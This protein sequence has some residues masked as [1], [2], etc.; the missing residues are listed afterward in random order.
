[1]QIQSDL[2]AVLARAGFELK[3]W[4]IN[5]PVLLSTIPDGDRAST[6][7]DFNG[8]E[9]P[10]VKVLGLQWDPSTDDFGYNVHIL[11]TVVTKRSVLS[12]IAQIFDPLGFL[13]P[14][15]FLAKHIMQLIWKANLS[16][17]DPLPASLAANWES[18]VADLPCLLNIR[19][20]RNQF[21]KT[22]AHVQLCGCCDASERGYSAVVYM[23][24]RQ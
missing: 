1:M 20:P 4:S 21:A 2:K 11:T 9:G 3:K 16:W 19:V 8:N 18:F 23:R 7:P 12:T 14:I 17:D 6:V 5:C 10:L 15:I 13:A 24:T 22:H